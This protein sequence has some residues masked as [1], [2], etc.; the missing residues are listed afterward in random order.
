MSKDCLGVNAKG[1]Q[2]PSVVGTDGCNN[3]H[4]RVDN[5]VFSGEG[6]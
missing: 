3:Y 6:Q 5:K 4:G 2:F 1:R